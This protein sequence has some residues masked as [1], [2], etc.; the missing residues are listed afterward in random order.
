[1]E[2]KIMLVI[3]DGCDLRY[4][5]QDIQEGDAISKAKMPY[6]DGLLRAYP[7]ML[8]KTSGK[9]VGL[10]DG[11]MGSSEVGHVN[12]GG[13]EP[14]GLA[15]Q[16]IS[17]SIE[18]GTFYEKEE[19][20]AVITAIHAKGGTA[21]L[22]I[23]L[24]NGGVHSLNSHLY[25]G[26][27]ACAMQGVPVSVHIKTDGRDTDVMSAT[28]YLEALDEEINIIKKEYPGVK[29]RIDT[30]EGR[31]WGMDRDEPWDKIERSFNA[32]A[33]AKSFDDQEN[34]VAPFSSWQEALLASYDAGIMDEF[35]RPVVINPD[36]QG[37]NPDRDGW[38]FLNFRTDRQKK[39]FAALAD[40]DFSQFDRGNYGPLT[41]RMVTATPYVQGNYN[42]PFLVQPRIPENTISS[43]IASEGGTQLKI[44]HSQKSNHVAGFINGDGSNNALL[45]QE[46][47]VVIKTDI[48][49]YALDPIMGAPRVTDVAI[50]AMQNSTDL[51][52]IN[53][54][55]LDMVGHT[56]DQA[57][58][59]L[60][61]ECVDEQLGRLVAANN[62]L[63]EPYIIMVVADHGN[64]GHMVRQDKTG[65]VLPDTQHSTGPVPFICID[66]Y[67]FGKKDPLDPSGWLF[68]PYSSN[69]GVSGALCDVGPTL[70]YSSG[71]GVPESMTGGVRFTDTDA[72][73]NCL[74][75]VGQS[76]L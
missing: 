8:V 70:L 73:S 13:G 20:K 66:P 58:V 40:P 18:D 27:R 69:G 61:A 75:R 45:P 67:R 51:V 55:N 25:A 33:H 36:Y 68:T 43:V 41:G 19:L 26:I 12:I 23:L 38:I 24:S 11:Q 65:K 35:I 76:G 4:Y 54:A 30:L 53:Y 31:S 59:I 37:V 3:L 47:R 71:R 6:L 15:L 16:P 5:D 74:E 17:E 22:D 29:I 1:M 21:H 14:N 10:P 42:C 56:G 50:D 63:E 72:L 32:I 64:A 52:V 28:E 34:I 7:S 9:D 44:S 49:N 57:A 62:E 48:D 46:K 2:K 39:Q 60:A